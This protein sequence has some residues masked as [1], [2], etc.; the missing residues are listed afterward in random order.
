MMLHVKAFYYILAVI[1]LH[2]MIGWVVPILFTAI[3]AGSMIEEH[4][5]TKATITGTV[6][7]AAGVAFTYIYYPDA[8]LLMMEKID[9]YLTDLGP[10]VIPVITIGLP[11]ALYALAGY[12]S[13]NVTYM[14]RKAQANNRLPG[15]PFYDNG[16]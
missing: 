7:N 10:W 9:L 8:G 4:Q 2:F 15:N 3:L 16:N 13:S 12:F 6:V 14:F 5:V 1:F 11:A